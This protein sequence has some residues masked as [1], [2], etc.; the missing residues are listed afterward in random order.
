MTDNPFNDPQSLNTYV[1]PTWCPGCG[2]FSI[3]LALK[4]ALVA[5]GLPKEQLV[6]VYDIGSSGNMAD[7]N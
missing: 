3:W 2:N 5:L 7:F 1:R 6:L 4:Q